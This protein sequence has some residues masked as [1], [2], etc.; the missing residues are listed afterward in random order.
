MSLNSLAMHMVMS[1]GNFRRLMR[2]LNNHTRHLTIS[3]VMHWVIHL[4]LGLGVS[5]QTISSSSVII[6]YKEAVS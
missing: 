2:L 6:F 5:K 3:K 4:M 1:L